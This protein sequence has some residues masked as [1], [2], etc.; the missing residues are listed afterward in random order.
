MI[1]LYYLVGAVIYCLYEC[2]IGSNI[3]WL[4]WKDRWFSNHYCLRKLRYTNISYSNPNSINCNDKCKNPPFFPYHIHWAVLFW[5]IAII[6]NILTFLGNLRAKTL[7]R[8]ARIQLKR[9]KIIQQE[10]VL[11][12]ELSKIENDLDEEI[13]NLRKKG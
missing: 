5:P 13:L 10:S 1:F 2:F 6:A 7:D 8:K 9:E 12:Q 11:E 4:S 3:K